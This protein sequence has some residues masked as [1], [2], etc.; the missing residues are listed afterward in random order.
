MVKVSSKNRIREI[1]IRKSLRQADLARMIGVFQ[2]EISEIETGKR[3][4]SVCLTKR[5][6]KALGVSLDDLFLA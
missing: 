3:K 2:S 4:P 5:I 6:A 1:R